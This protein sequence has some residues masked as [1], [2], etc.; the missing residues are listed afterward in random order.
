MCRAHSV[1]SCIPKCKSGKRL[2]LLGL[3]ISVLVVFGCIDAD[4]CHSCRMSA[5]LNL[6]NLN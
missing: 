4:W 3:T 2:C 5:K 1:S 6:P